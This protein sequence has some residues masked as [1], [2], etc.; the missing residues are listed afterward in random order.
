MGTISGQ[1]ILNGEIKHSSSDLLLLSSHNGNFLHVR[2]VL[3]KAV[4]NNVLISVNN[5]F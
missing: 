2:C 5:I 1:D 3:I 4:K